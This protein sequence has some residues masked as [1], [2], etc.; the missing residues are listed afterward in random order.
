MSSRIYLN[1]TKDD[2]YT[3]EVYTDA[4]R[5]YLVYVSLLDKK[6]DTVY[7]SCPLGA[8][9]ECAHCEDVLDQFDVLT[10]KETVF[11]ADVFEEEV[12]YF[13]LEHD[14]IDLDAVFGK[15]PMDVRYVPVFV[16]GIDW[17]RAVKTE[18]RGW[19]SC[20]QNFAYDAEMHRLA[21][22]CTC[23][24]YNNPCEHVLISLKEIV[25]IFGNTFFKPSY[26]DDRK[27]EI[28]SQFH[29]TLDD[30]YSDIF[31]FELS[32]EGFI[33]TPKIDLLS[34]ASKQ[35][36]F[37]LPSI[38]N[39]NRDEFPSSVGDK[40]GLGFCLEVSLGEFHQ[41]LPFVGKYNKD[42]TA[43][44]TGFTAVNFDRLKDLDHGIPAGVDFLLKT[45]NIQQ[46]SSSDDPAADKTTYDKIIKL[47]N[48]ILEE[49]KAHSFFYK[50]LQDKLAAVH[51]K[52]LSFSDAPVTLSFELKKTK[53]HFNLKAFIAIDGDTSPLDAPNFIYSPTFIFNQ[54]YIYPIT[55]SNFGLALS[56][57]LSKPESNYLLSDAAS[58]Y[59]NILNPL[60]KHFVINS[61][62]FVVVKTDASADGQMQLYLKDAGL[63]LVSFSPVVQYGSSF[64]PLYQ[65]FSGWETDGAQSLISV[66]RD[67]ALEEQFRDLMS[68][69]HPLF[70]G[71]SL[72]LSTD[73]M[74][75]NDWFVNAMT[76]LKSQGV[77]VFGY[78]DL[79]SFHVNPNKASISYSV[80]S[81]LDWFDLT[82][83][84]AFGKEAVSLTALQKAFF[85]KSKYVQLTDGTLGI[86]PND[87]MEKFAGLFQV[88]K[89]KGEA[90]EFSQYHLGIIDPIVEV[91]EDKPEFLLEMMERKE[92]LQN[93]SL[94]PDQPLPAGV[95]ATLRPYQIS[96][97]NWLTFLEANRL[98]GCL[99]DDMGLGKT[100][101]TITFLKHVKDHATSQKTNLIVSPTSLVFNWMAEI[102]KF[103]PDLTVIIYS[104]SKR[105]PLIKKFPQAD[106][107]LSTYG[108]LLN[109]AE[110]LRDFPF[111]YIILDESQ[112]IKNAQSKRFKA[113]MQLQSWNRLLLTGTPIENNTFDLYAQMHFAN[114]GLLG[115]KVEFKKQFAQAIDTD[116]KEDVAL[117]LNQ[118]I[119]PFVLRRTKEQVAK[120]LPEKTET[121][122]Y[123]E[124]GAAQ[125]SVYEAYKNKYRDFLL[126]KAASDGIGQTQLYVL[127][128]LLKLR[129]I[130]NGTHL[131][132]DPED[133]GAYSVKIDVLMENI[134]DKTGKHKVLVF[135]QFVQMLKSIEERLQ[136]EGIP[137]AYLDG[138]TKDR[139]QKVSDFQDNDQIR[140]FLISLKA[141]GTGLNLTAADYVFLV[142]PW[143]NPAVESQAIDRSYRIGQDKK[144]MA[145]R[146]I[147]KDTIEEK[148][149]QMQ[150]KKRKIADG[151]ISV[152]IDKKVFD[153]QDI[154]NLFK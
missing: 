113:L 21:Y 17:P 154:K 8:D 71:D 91:L 97:F 58:F 56:Y 57:F 45:Y 153:I 117:L 42:Q 130:C 2:T 148:M 96:G 135:S 85:N 94:Q 14:V 5:V 133:Y 131:L 30:N 20:V 62:K 145:Y 128:G 24:Q 32:K 150:Q 72:L 142:D 112:H 100:L 127:E 13:T 132:S 43:L 144:V 11:D 77:T 95:R 60:S 23:K 46:F 74:L 3:F 73:D 19:H 98:G 4:K 75:Q 22:D 82:V 109:D 7:C 18:I 86:L 122:L 15:F 65:K 26:F 37:L 140:V 141:G 80:K 31:E 59:Q 64:I 63:D 1:A 137:Y 106:V 68:G 107:I 35:P 146:M 111:H 104:G 84:V 40:R 10:G 102:Q 121:I 70:S 129:Q 54:E 28:L 149:L 41:L 53:T 90:L 89:V 92:R 6:I 66:Q 34:N 9:G 99:A 139:A 76:F 49:L 69:L 83:K 36:D 126:D 38:Y 52:P 123:C 134:L 33:V 61:G 87:W 47:Q 136:M 114:P 118:M 138:Q 108:T 115:N 48:K 103:C 120:D 116:K 151:I 55:D 67:A 101:Q 93:L 79:K 39:E 12:Y 78:K 119:K 143:W 110:L 50:E 88:G 51:L 81:E 152:D 29:M 44:K 124:M 105:Q 25:D 125:R 27:L 147:C 16:E